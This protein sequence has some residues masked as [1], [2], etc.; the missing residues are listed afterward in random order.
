MTINHTTWL[1]DWDTGDSC[2]DAN[3]NVAVASAPYSIAQDVTTALRTFLGECW[4][5]NTLGVAYWQGILGE[6][7]PASYIIAQLEGQA[8][9]VPDVATADATVGG[10]NSA[11]GLICQMVVTDT[12]GT[13]ITI[14]G[15]VAGGQI[16]ILATNQGSPI[17]IGGM[18]IEI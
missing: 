8:L 6:R 17:T 16:A 14:A 7:P 18:Y 1:L 3:G 9:L 2:L 15:G 12:D 10:V 4:Y 13:T 5:D 11:R